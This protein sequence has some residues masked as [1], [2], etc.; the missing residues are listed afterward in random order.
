MATR[1]G[2]E[3]SLGRWARARDRKPLLLCG[4]RRTG[5]TRAL[6][7]LGGTRFDDVVHVDFER[8][9]DMAALFTQGA[10]ADRALRDLGLLAGRP[11]TPKTLLILDEIHAC[12][13]AAAW[14]TSVG[15]QVPGQPVAAT[16]SLP[17]AIVDTLERTPSPGAVQVLPAGPL[18]FEEFLRALDKEA[19]ADA[20]RERVTAG[21]PM[22]AP[23]HAACLRLARSYLLVGGMPQAVAA[24]AQGE[25]FA[26]VTEAQR[27]ILDALS[28]DILRHCPRHLVRRAGA[29]FDSL[30][31]QLTK[32]NR[33]FQYGMVRRGGTAMA[34]EPAMDWLAN[35]G[36]VLKSPRVEEAI[37]PLT[38]YAMPMTF[39]AYM[40]DVGL[41]ACRLNARPAAVLFGEAGRAAGALVEN[42]VAQQLRAAG[43]ALHHWVSPNQVSVDFV[44]ETRGGMLGVETGQTISPKSQRLRAFM[45][46][47]GLSRSL[48][49]SEA[50]FRDDGSILSL[51]IYAVFCIHRPEAGPAPLAG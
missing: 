32:P 41:L 33:R 31:A 17:G 18:D 15:G 43:H 44:L 34:Y 37:R 23:L 46:R 13:G 29:A 1:R 42:F 30:P 50:A 47:Y 26:A 22:P 48:Q 3:T 10:P 14:L 28:S 24:F 51:P 4:P 9:R 11:I 21:A 49:I 12:P 6:L 25:D 5:K 8:D 45:A 20:I 40:P 7:D 39:R 27:E 38:D 16:T 36:L 2:L 19:L 35:S